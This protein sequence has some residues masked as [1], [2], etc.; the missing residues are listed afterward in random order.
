MVLHGT[1]A[2]YKEFNM[3][4]GKFSVLAVASCLWLAGCGGGSGGSSGS[5]ASGAG[6][7]TPAVAVGP[8]AAFGSVFVN[9]VEYDTNHASFD[10][11]GA[12]ASGDG[13]LSVGMV[14]R[15]TGSHDGNGHGIATAIRYDSEIDGPVTDVMVDAADSTIKHFSIFGQEVLANATTVF[16]SK[17]GT[18]YTFDDLANGDHIEVS[19]D[20]DGTVLVASFVER[21]PASDQTYEVRGTVSG[22]NGSTFVLTLAGGSM[23]NVTLDAGASVPAGLADGVLVEV[24]GAVPDAT[25]PLDLLAQRVKL[26]DHDDFDGEG[27]GEHEDHAELGGT[28]AFDGTTWSIRGTPLSFSSST[29]YQPTSLKAAI[30]DGSAAGLRVEVHGPVVDGVLDVQKI[31]AAGRAD[32]AGDLKLQGYVSSVTQDATAGTTTIKMSFPPV[33]GT[34][35]VIVDSQ[36]LLMNDQHLAGVD[37]STLV[38]DVSFI[39]VHGH[40]DA[41]GAFVAGALHVEDHAGAYEVSGPVDT[42]GFVPGVSIS[43]LGV[44]FSV[45][46]GTA[47]DGGTPADGTFV[48]VKDV[49]RD[50]FAD[51]VDHEDHH[52]GDF[53]RA[54]RH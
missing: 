45:D 11:R 3:R 54:E 48:E 12:S 43:V 22:L 31:R 1:A 35:D 46:A 19:G 26:E 34:I 39:D 4:F 38:P 21:K 40:L 27:K 24:A 15:V 8:I 6:A 44:K 18:S 32:G 51:E 52:D 41:S 16:K 5:L 36:T 28:L 14:V 53:A 42:D 25:Q 2:V 29:A 37:L 17:D 7:Q 20:F 50:G 30:G 10:V 33:Q 49:D 23:L 13:A 9:G 47:I